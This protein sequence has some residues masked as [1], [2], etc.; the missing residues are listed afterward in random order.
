V[1]ELIEKNIPRIFLPGIPDNFFT[2]C[3]TR[4]LLLW[5]QSVMIDTAFCIV[6][7]R[8]VQ[9]Y[10]VT[11]Q[12]VERMEQYCRTRAQLEAFRAHP[13]FKQFIKKWNLPVYFQLRFQEIAVRF[14]ATLTSP[15]QSSAVLDLSQGAVDASCVGVCRY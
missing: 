15:L 4:L 1:T 6:R 11:M 3:V 13:A 12:F 8:R 10:N 7:A 9:N 5:C 2:V 14:E